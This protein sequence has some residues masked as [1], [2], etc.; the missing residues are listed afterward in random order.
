MRAMQRHVPD[1]PGRS[2]TGPRIQP[3]PVSATLRRFYLVWFLTPKMR[4][5]I[6]SW[7]PR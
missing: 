1:A 7:L 5:L 3:C 4:A 6:A 2:T